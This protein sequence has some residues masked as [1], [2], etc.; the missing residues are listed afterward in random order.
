MTDALKVLAHQ[1][2]MYAYDFIVRRYDVG[3]KEGYL[4][5]QVEYVLRREDLEDQFKAYLQN[6]IK[7]I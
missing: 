5:A 2:D 4:E 7:I 1:Q 6:I 3:D